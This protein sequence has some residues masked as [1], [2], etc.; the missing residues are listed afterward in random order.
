MSRKDYYQSGK[1]LELRAHVRHRCTN[2]CEYCWLR[3]MWSVHH[4]TYSRFGRELL[5]DL[6]GVCSECHTFIEGRSQEILVAHRCL[7]L[8]DSGFGEESSAW[9]H[10]LEKYAFT[11]LNWNDCRRIVL[12]RE[13]GK[14]IEKHP[15]CYLCGKILDV[16]S[17]GP[18]PCS[19]CEKITKAEDVFCDHGDFETAALLL[20][21]IENE[22]ISN[23]EMVERADTIRRDIFFANPK[24]AEL[25]I[26]KKRER[27]WPP[28]WLTD[29]IV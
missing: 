9:K 18:S 16:P 25:K 6:M 7:A 14:V 11:Q 2:L 15:A 27:Q 17:D 20:K 5:T 10:Y 24:N 1:W 19:V 4:R 22:P 8:H 13:K 23:T 12:V 21:E 29:D 26:P 3:E 28:D